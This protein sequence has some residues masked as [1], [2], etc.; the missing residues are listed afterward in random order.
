MRLKPISITLSGV[1]LSI[2]MLI[3][4][5]L[6]GLSKCSISD[7]LQLIKMKMSII[8]SIIEHLHF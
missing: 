4:S 7:I 6:N 5:V 1:I 2:F 3:A 8:Q